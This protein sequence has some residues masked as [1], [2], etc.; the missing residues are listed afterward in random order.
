MPKSK[1]HVPY[2]ERKCLSRTVYY[3]VSTPISV[4]R[5]IKPTTTRQ[6]LNAI[7]EKKQATGVAELCVGFPEEAAIHMSYVCNLGF[8]VTFDYGFLR[9]IDYYAQYQRSGRQQPIRPFATPMKAVDMELL[10]KKFTKPRKAIDNR[11]ISDCMRR[12]CPLENR[13][14]FSSYC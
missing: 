5:G 11:Y 9:V 1:Q 3:L 7:G 12:S 10:M 14:V 4:E 6:K 8:E 2:R 13:I